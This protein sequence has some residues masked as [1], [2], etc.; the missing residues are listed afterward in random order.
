MAAETSQDAALLALGK[1]FDTAHAQFQDANERLPAFKDAYRAIAPDGNGVLFE[2]YRDGPWRRYLELYHDPTSPTSRAMKSE[3]GFRMM[4]VC[5]LQIDG[6]VEKGFADPHN[7]KFIRAK[8]VKFEEQ[9][10]AAEHASGLAGAMNE[11]QSAEA[12]LRRIVHQIA[13]CRAAT[14][15]GVALKVRATA[16]YAALGAEERFTASMWLAKAV[17]SDLGEDV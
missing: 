6:H 17:W 2:E 1:H 3:R 4:K 15:A 7:V 12:E 16:A 5:R 14:L 10:K 9:Q 11:Y 8:V 13:E